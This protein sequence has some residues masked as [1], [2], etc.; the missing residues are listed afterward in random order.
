MALFEDMDEEILAS[1]P[2][3]VLLRVVEQIDDAFW[4]S[5]HLVEGDD[6]AEVLYV[7]AVDAAKH[8]SELDSAAKH[9]VESELRRK[10]T[11]RDCALHQA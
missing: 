11:G 2:D 10:H 9:N 7:A 3:A 6:D 8:N 5:K 4:V 1:N